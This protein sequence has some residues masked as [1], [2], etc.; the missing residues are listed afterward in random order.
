VG[1]RWC[2]FKNLILLAGKTKDDED[3]SGSITIPEVAHDTEEDEYV[4][5]FPCLRPLSLVCLVLILSKFDIDIFSETASKEPV[6]DLV[7]RKL[8]PQLRQHLATLGP[9]LIK[10][11]A[12]DLQHEPG[13]S[14]VTT[15]KYTS[16]SSIS[17]STDSAKA[18]SSSSTTTTASGG[19]GPAVNVTKVTDQEE[20]RT[21]AAQLYQTFTDPQRVA[22][23][24]R[25]P[26]RVFEAKVGGHFELFGGNVSG[27]FVEL[28]QPTKIV[29]KW[30][31]AQWPQGHYSTL[32]IV[33][34]Q[35]DVDAVTVMRVDWEGVPVGQEEVTKRNWGE[36]YVRSI[37]TT[38]GFGT[39]L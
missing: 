2:D 36:Y 3:V 11:H 15:P 13:Y 18:N 12:K 14:T 10:E 4:V 8:T 7:R 26:P 30:R 20:F 21:E 27:E 1:P 32:K 34:D 28:E 31:L 23:F 29:Q 16:S 19:K 25:A 24:T 38:F 6:K 35:N 39:I 17:K 33:F 37:K 9:A 5:R 22:A